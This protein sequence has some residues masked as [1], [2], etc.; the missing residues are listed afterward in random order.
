MWKYIDTLS[1]IAR[2]YVSVDKIEQAKDLIAEMKTRIT[3][4]PNDNDRDYAYGSLS[5]ALATIGQI[6]QAI[7][8][9]QL[10]NTTGSRDEAIY[11]LAQVYA[12]QGNITHALAE[13]KSITHIRRRIAL[14]LS[15]GNEYR[16]D[17]S[18]KISLI[19]KE[20]QA[21]RTIED[22]WELLQLINPLLNDYPWLGTVILEEEKWVNAQLKRLG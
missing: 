20:W 8:T 6:T 9:I 15:L 3:I 4:L 18:L 7:E 10:I 11:T 12:A 13:A 5:Q 22:T 19:Q 21:S 17:D 1:I 2:S 14:F 16:D